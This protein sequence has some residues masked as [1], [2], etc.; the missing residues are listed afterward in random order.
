M[1]EL[2][3]AFKALAFYGITP[4]AGIALAI[5]FKIN[6]AFGVH[7]KRLALLEQTTAKCK[8]C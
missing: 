5:L 6:K 2:L 3:P 4:T 7:D 1:I 8:E